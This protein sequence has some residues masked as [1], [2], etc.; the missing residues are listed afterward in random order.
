VQKYWTFR[1]WIRYLSIC[2]LLD[3]LYACK[4]VFDLCKKNG[5][6]YIITFKEGSMSDVYKW[7]C[8]NRDNLCKDNYKEVIRDRNTTQEYRW[9]TGLEHYNEVDE[10]TIFECKEIVRSND[11][12]KSIK[13][14][15]WVTNISISK[16]NVDKIANQG[17]RLRWKIENQGF[18]MQKQ[19][20]Y[21]LEH[22]YSKHPIGMMNFYLMLQIAHIIDQLMEKGLLSKETIK[23]KLGSIRNIAHQLL[24]DLKYK[25]IDKNILNQSF[26]IRLNS[27]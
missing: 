27:S 4:P 3:S 14:F 16:S 17:G 22:A 2:L 15:V 7:Y 26:Q 19:G 11:K 8:T 12:L 21:K 6:K 9:I 24:E 20:G 10:Y 1:G 18:N 25:L 23:Y 13:N 5:W